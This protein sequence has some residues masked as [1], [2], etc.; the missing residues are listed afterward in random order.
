MQIQFNPKVANELLGQQFWNQLALRFIRIIR[1]RTRQ[2]RDMNGQ[3]FKP[4]SKGYLKKRQADGITSSTVNLEYSRQGGML[5]NIDHMVSNTFDSVTI[6]F[7]DARARQLA[8]YHNEMGAG[9]SRII[10]KFFGI[11]QQSAQREFSQID[12][13]NIHKMFRN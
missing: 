7:N 4:Y 8:L 11:T 13:S 3:P 12:Y 10:R 9:K 1:T 6:Y 5:K 2:G